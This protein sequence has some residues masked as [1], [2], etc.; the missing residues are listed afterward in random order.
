MRGPRVGDR[1]FDLDYVDF[2]HYG[3]DYNSMHLS[4]DDKPPFQC[5]LSFVY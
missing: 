4:L 3:V 5:L 2:I 1:A